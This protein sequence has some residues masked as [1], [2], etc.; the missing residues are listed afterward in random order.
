MTQ[1][2]AKR[3]LFDSCSRHHFR[4]GSDLCFSYVFRAAR[5]DRGENIQVE[6]RM[7]IVWYGSSNQCFNFV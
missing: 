6:S 2:A 3:I 7:V 1:D 4:D 5:V